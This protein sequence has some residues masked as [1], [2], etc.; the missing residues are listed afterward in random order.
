MPPLLFLIA[1]FGVAAIFDRVSGLG[2]VKRDTLVSFLLLQLYT[3]ILGK[4]YHHFQKT[5]TGMGEFD[6]AV[7]NLNYTDVRHLLDQIVQETR[8]KHGIKLVKKLIK[9]YDKIHPK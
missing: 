7:D 9:N 2:V 3:L 5:G 1:V 6:Q 4:L 8:R